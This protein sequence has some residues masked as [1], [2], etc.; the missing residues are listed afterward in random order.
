VLYFK[1]FK[2]VSF[3]VVAVPV[4]L[5][6]ERRTTR[7]AL[8]RDSLMPVA[9]EAIVGLVRLETSENPENKFIVLNYQMIDGLLYLGKSFAQL[10]PT[11]TTTGSE[12]LG[13]L[14]QIQAGD[15]GAIAQGSSG[16]LSFLSLPSAQAEQYEWFWAQIRS[17][18]EQM[19]GD[20]LNY[21]QRLLQAL[22]QIQDN[23]ESA[24]HSSTR[25][26]QFIDQLL[27]LGG[28]YA[29]LEPKAIDP[30]ASDPELFLKTLWREDESVNKAIEELDSYLQHLENYHIVLKQSRILL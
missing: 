24:L 21:G 20:R 2:P 15:E 19:L 22:K 4:L 5:V 3:E 25:E 27:L 28:A 16:L 11:A 18:Q 14:W 1:Y 23:P 8:Y 17:Q 26:V 7:G 12:F 10:N 6:V 30:V 9:V 29:G 13:A